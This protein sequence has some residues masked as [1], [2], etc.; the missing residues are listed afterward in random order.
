MKN[1]K[2]CFCAHFLTKYSKTTLDKIVGTLLSPYPSLPQCQNEHQE[3]RNSSFV[4]PSPPVN[5][6]I[7]VAL[8]KLSSNE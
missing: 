6:E 5:A 7:K 1:A 2:K 8:A 4:P 3:I